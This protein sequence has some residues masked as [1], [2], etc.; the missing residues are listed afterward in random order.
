LSEVEILMKELGRHISDHTQIF[1]GTAVDTRMGNRLS[2]TL[3]SSVSPD[4]V[5]AEP[6]KKTFLSPPIEPPPPAPAP[7]WEQR[8]EPPTVTEAPAEETETSAPATEFAQFE[9]VNPEHEVE[10]EEK[11]VEEI[12][13]PPIPVTAR[14]KPSVLKE[15]KSP[16]EKKQA[17][18]EV[19]QF[20]PVTRG[21]F[22]KS[23]PTIVEGQD[24]DVPTFLRKNVRVK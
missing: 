14:K 5:V 2:V 1:F 18:Q 17:K 21:R 10:I 6:P 16:A 19:L 13:P 7:I 8:E 23:E 12:V 22:E 20:E 3:I 11:A 4:G 15:P 9:Q 24:L